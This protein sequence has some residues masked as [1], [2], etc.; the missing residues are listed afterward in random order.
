[1]KV[2]PYILIY[3]LI[4][5]PVFGIAAENQH[6]VEEG[7]AMF[8][9]ISTPE[10]ASVAINKINIGTTPLIDVPLL[11]GVYEVHVKLDNYK[12]IKETVNLKS[13]EDSK[14]YVMLHKPLDPVKDE[15]QVDSGWF[16]SDSFWTAFWIS[17]GITCLVTILIIANGMSDMN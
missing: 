16:R 4:L 8:S 14:L 9:V 7:N 11:P 12:V 6:D 1:M 2:I 15:P 10:G 5:T 17:T 13:N 3:F